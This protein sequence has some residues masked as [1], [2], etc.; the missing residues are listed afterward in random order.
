LARKHEFL[1]LIG[2]I[3]AEADRIVGQK[4][5]DF[6]PMRLFEI[7]R[8]A[9]KIALDLAKPR[10]DKFA[11]AIAELSSLTDSQIEEI[12]RPEGEYLGRARVTAALDKIVYSLGEPK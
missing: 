7:H 1:G 3:R 4:Y 5:V 8:E 12:K 9:A 11:D 10:R 6:F 2:G